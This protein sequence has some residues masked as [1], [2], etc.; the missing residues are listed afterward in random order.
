MCRFIFSFICVKI[1]QFFLELAIKSAG[2][3]KYSYLFYRK[4]VS[5]YLRPSI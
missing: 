3:G 4:Y 1:G 2:K 5:Y